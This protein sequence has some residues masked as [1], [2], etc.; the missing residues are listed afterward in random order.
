MACIQCVILDFR[1]K[2]SVECV[3]CCSSVSAC[4]VIAILRVNK[5][6][7]GCTLYKSCSDSV[8]GNVEHSLSHG[9]VP[10]G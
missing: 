1:V 8:G 4:I 5:T 6:E 7:T 9:K 10:H 3:Y 2:V